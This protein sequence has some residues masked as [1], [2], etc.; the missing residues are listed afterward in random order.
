[1]KEVSNNKRLNLSTKHRTY[2]KESSKK[3]KALRRKIDELE[4]EVERLK[5]ELKTLNK[6]FKKTSIYIDDKLD[7]ISLE[8]VISGV[9]Q[10][11]TMSETISENF[12]PSC[13]LGELRVDLL[14]FG[15][16]V[17]CNKGCGHRKV[18]KHEEEDL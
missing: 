8:S 12:C 17:I 13:Q 6:V 9:K 14:P 11:K 16:L 10:N 15:K 18:I 3:E 2:P 4:R 5:G 7:G 1:M